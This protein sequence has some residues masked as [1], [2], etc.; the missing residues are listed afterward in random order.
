MKR[1]LCIFLALMLLC[2]CSSNVIPPEKEPSFT[3]V[4]QNACDDSIHGIGFTYISDNNRETNV[5]CTDI[6]NEWIDED[7]DWKME[8]SFPMAQSFSARI[9][10]ISTN[11]VQYCKAGT[12]AIAPEMDGVYEFTLT[13]NEEEGYMLQ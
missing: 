11:G 12:I 3:I 13:G 9:F 7:E 8:K 6:E 1:L 5:L 10:V 2:A 4:V